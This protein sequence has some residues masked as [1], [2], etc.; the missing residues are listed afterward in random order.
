MVDSRFQ[1]VDGKRQMAK[2]ICLVA[3]VADFRGQFAIC[4]L[5]FVVRG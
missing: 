2:R 4:N 3:D 1:M 5:Q